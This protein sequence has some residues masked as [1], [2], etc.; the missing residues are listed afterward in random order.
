MQLDPRRLSLEIYE[1]KKRFPQFR[2]IRLQD[3]RI[4]YVGIIRTM[5]WNQYEIIIVYPNN[6]PHE[7]PKVYSISP[8]ISTKHQFKDGSLCFHLSHEWSPSFT[9]C[10]IV[11]WTSHWLHAYENY[12]RTGN[13]PGRE[14]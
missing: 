3:G 4:G 14:A 10:V 9:V 7:A 12:L 6:Y 11:G 2:P 13:W 5:S 8:P 1:M